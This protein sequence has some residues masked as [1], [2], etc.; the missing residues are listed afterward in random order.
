MDATGLMVVPVRGT[1]DAVS[2]RCGRSSS[3]ERVGIAFTT[4]ARLAETMG[5]EQPW[6]YVDE[7]AL[8]AM[9]A[10]LGVSRITVDPRVV[11]P[12][13]PVSLAV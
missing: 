3:D 2:L 12:P 10:P 6:I 9:L 4:E 7:R 1:S 8:R 5:A 13:H 11:A